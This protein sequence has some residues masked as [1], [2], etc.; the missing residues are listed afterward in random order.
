MS[1][2]VLRLFSFGLDVNKSEKSSIEG[3]LELF[4]QADSSIVIVSGELNDEFYGDL[5]ICNALR[6]AAERGVT[7]KIAC[8][9]QVSSKMLER[10]RKL[11]KKYSN[12]KF[13]PLSE[14]PEPHFMLIDGRTVRAQLGHV[15]GTQEHRA[16]VRHDSPEVAARFSDYFDYLVGKGAPALR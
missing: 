2:S 7:L 3:C 13:Y 16:V 1:N 5:R 4:N 12:V 8:G 14:R 11:E 9:P 15:A 10:T 6:D